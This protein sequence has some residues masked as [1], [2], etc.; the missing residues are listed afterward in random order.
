MSR[1]LINEVGNKYGK[2]LVLKRAKNDKYNCTMWLCQCDCGNQ[3]AIH[4]GNLRNG[5]TKSCGCL[6]RST[7]KGRG[8]QP[9]SEGIASFNRLYYNYK[10]A[11]KR[12][13]IEWSIT[14]IE[15]RELTKQNCYYCNTSPMQKLNYSGYNSAYIYNGLDRL[16][17]S[18]GY[19]IDNVV[20]C[21]GLCNWMKKD[22][23]IK[24]FLD[25]IAKIARIHLDGKN[26]KVG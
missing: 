21:C 10:Y 5:K 18:K 22:N 14:K 7:V 15:F 13:N 11:A 2:L 16:D 19:I 26:A 17:N 6:T 23:S 25:H 24:E 12:R 4:G 8:R 1:K 9:L 20:P 3:K